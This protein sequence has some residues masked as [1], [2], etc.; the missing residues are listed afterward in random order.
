MIR[1]NGN[2]ISVKVTGETRSNALI[3][4]LKDLDEPNVNDGCKNIN[5]T[6]SAFTDEIVS[7]IESGGL[8]YAVYETEENDIK[9][10]VKMHVDKYKVA[11]APEVVFS[12]V[13]GNVH[14]QLSCN[15]CSAI[16]TITEGGNGGGVTED[17]VNELIAE[18]LA[19]ITNAEDMSV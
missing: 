2:D 6:I 19:N 13:G 16:L 17:R 18:A 11:P 3:V 7:H 9:T 4:M 8:A 14:Y 1:I 5:C 10:S 15:G 12:S